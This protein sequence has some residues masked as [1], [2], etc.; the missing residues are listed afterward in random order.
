LLGELTSYYGQPGYNVG[1]LI[2]DRWRCLTLK[3]V[4]YIMSQVAQALRFLHLNKI[5][6]LDL[7]PENILF[8]KNFSVKLIDF[9][10]SFHPLVPY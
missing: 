4:I 9:G 10:E 6:H 7:K 3:K 1:H 8:Q 5:V 2:E